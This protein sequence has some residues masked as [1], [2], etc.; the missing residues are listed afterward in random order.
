MESR[1]AVYAG[2]FDPYTNGHKAIVK[3]AAKLFD[4]LYI[5]IGINSNKKRF[6]DK[7]DMARAIKDDLEKEGITNCKVVIHNGLVATYCKEH[8]IHYSVRGLRNN[9]DYNYE[10]NIS[11][12]N[13]LI[14]TELETVYLRTDDRAT[15]SS[16]IRELVNYGMEVAKFVPDSVLEILDNMG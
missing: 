7:F 13:K 16:M 14:N 4:E 9:M 6:T 1:K 8:N 5:L 11:E 10:E 3:K 2:S 15:S 12:V